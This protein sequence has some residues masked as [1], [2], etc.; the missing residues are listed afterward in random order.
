VKRCAPRDS[1]ELGLPRLDGHV[2]HARAIVTWQ[3][4]L[5][6]SED[7]E[8]EPMHWCLYVLL[9]SKA[10]GHRVWGTWSAVE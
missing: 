1:M 6:A 7:S 8:V 5:I 9:Q 4:S 10:K 3:D 2:N